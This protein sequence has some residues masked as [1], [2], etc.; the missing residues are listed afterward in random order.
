MRQ[1]A[2]FPSNRR[3]PGLNVDSNATCLNT[4][5]P[6]A[7]RCLL[8]T[9]KAG[10]NSTPHRLKHAAVNSIQHTRRASRFSLTR[11]QFETPS[12]PCRAGFTVAT[13]IDKEFECDSACFYASSALSASRI[14]VRGGTEVCPC[15]ATLLASMGIHGH[16]PQPLAVPEF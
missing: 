14:P 8:F 3:R 6:T 12:F 10:T 16:A 2:K 4:F 15:R 11:K 9:F 13:T 7:S 5:A 1:E